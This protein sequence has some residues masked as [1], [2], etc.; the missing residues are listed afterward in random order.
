MNRDS[1]AAV[2]ALAQVEIAD[3]EIVLGQQVREPPDPLARGA[4]V[5]GVGELA[6]EGT[7]LLDRLPGR[8]LVPVRLLVLLVVAEGELVAGVVAA[9][10]AG[11]AI[12]VVAVAVP[13]LR[14]SWSP[15]F[16]W[17]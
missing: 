16:C 10:R 15:T 13:G 11:V 5:A 9:G 12:Q 6:D 14:C 4:G 8:G 3:P 17:K 1:A 7:V 2:D